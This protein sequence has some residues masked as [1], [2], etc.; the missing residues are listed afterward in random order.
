MSRIPNIILITALCSVAC[1]RIGPSADFHIGPS[2]ENFPLALRPNGATVTVQTAGQTVAGELLAVRDDGVVIL[3][4]SKLSLV[5]YSDLRSVKV[6]D[7]TDYSIGAGAPQ[8]APRAKLNA[9]SR[10]PQGISAALQQKLFA[11]S[12]QAELEVLR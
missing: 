11:Q 6:V 8:P 7:L 4:G 5:S 1:F 2:A 9:L 12:G 10:Y 3:H